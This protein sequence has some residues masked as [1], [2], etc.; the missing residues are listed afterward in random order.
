MIFEEIKIS[1][2]LKEP[3]VLEPY[4]FKVFRVPKLIPLYVRDITFILL[5]HPLTKSKTKDGET[6]PFV[7]LS[8]VNKRERSTTWTR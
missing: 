2:I 1:D 5:L 7:T 3:V 6:M 4:I 8:H